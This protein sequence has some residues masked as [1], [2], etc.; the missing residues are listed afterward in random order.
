VQG[1]CCSPAPT[2][3]GGTGCCAVRAPCGVGTGRAEGDRH[4]GQTHRQAARGAWSRCGGQACS[5]RGCRAVDEGAWVTPQ[6]P[7][8]RGTRLPR[9]VP[10]ASS[11]RFFSARWQPARPPLPLHQPFVSRR[12]G[13]GG[14]FSIPP[15]PRW[16][17]S[18][19]PDSH[20]GAS[21][22]AGAAVLAGWAL[23]PRARRASARC[24]QLGGSWRG[25]KMKS[26]WRESSGGLRG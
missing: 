7:R 10:T 5:P 24:R 6:W 14:V 4:Q 17:L 16:R 13:S 22:G 20:P 15:I 19:L 8:S 18:H 2:R 1:G 25:G 12:F 9:L 26:Y 23:L 11:R 3:H 21:S